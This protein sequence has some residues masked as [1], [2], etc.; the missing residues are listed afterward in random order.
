MMATVRTIEGTQD[1][2]RFGV[3]KFSDGHKRSYQVD[4]L[5]GLVRLFWFEK[6]VRRVEPD[7]DPRRVSAAQT[8]IRLAIAGSQPQRSGA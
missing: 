5:S 7:L 8:A 6:G 4:L 1:A 2:I 3:V